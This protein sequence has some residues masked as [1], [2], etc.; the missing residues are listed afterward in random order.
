MCCACVIFISRSFD[1]SALLFF[2]SLEY[3]FFF[4]SF[5]FVVVVVV[6]GAVTVTVVVAAVVFCFFTILLFA[7]SSFI[8]F[9]KFLAPSK[10]SDLL[11]ASFTRSF[12]S[13]YR[14]NRCVFHECVPGSGFICR[15]SSFRFGK[16]KKF[17]FKYF[18]VVVY[19]IIYISLND[20][21]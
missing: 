16:K 15:F 3:F 13:D 9:V 11:F 8:Q 6:V 12:R 1:F 18:V 20:D 4:F 19:F 5:K 21:S 2:T 14:L 7:I 10:F 17:G